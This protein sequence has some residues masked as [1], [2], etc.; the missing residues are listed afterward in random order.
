MLDKQIERDVSLALEEDVGDQDVTGQ[1][2]PA[3]QYLVAEVITREPMVMAGKAW[4]EQAFVQCDSS[5]EIDWFADDGQFL[6]ASRR[7]CQIKGNSR[8]ILKAERV[9]LN[10]LQLL[11]GV[12]TKV[13]HYVDKVPSTTAVLD[14]RKT[15][16][17]L[18]YAQKYAVRCGG[19]QNH[20][21]GLYDAYLIKENHIKAFG[22][23]R[24]VLSAAKALRPEL[25]LEIEVENLQ[26]LQQA[27]AGPVDIIMLDNFSLEMLRDA[28]AMRGS[29][30]VK[31]EASGNVSLETIT[32]IAA[33]GVDYISIGDL[34]KSVTAIDLSLRVLAND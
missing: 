33:T 3:E 8:A 11:S 32:D 14:S 17:S 4:F 20:R 30:A 1:L 5:I 12:A 16:P 2:L 6:Q 23:I 22:S 34:T 9:A 24:Q 19:G 7:L 26:E 27:L 29:Q 31:F 28:V 21:M 25:P 18:R 10:F 13:K 15:L